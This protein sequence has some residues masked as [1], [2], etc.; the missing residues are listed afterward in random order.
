MRRNLFSL[1]LL[2]CTVCSMAGTLDKFTITPE[3][4][5][6]VT[7]DD[8]KQVT[9]TFPDA[10]E[11]EGSGWINIAVRDVN[12][13]D[14]RPPLLYIKVD[15]D[16]KM[17]FEGNQVI[18]D[19]SEAADLKERHLLFVLNAP[20]FYDKDTKDY[21]S[22][23]KFTYNLPELPNT[24][25]TMVVTPSMDRIVSPVNIRDVTI[26]FPDV[27]IM[28]FA[29]LFDSNLEVWYND[30]KIQ[31]LYPGDNASRDDNKVSFIIYSWWIETVPGKLELKFGDKYFKDE[32]SGSESK[33]FTLAWNIDNKQD[34]GIAT[35]LSDG[36]DSDNT[37]TI[38]GTRA[39][40]HVN[41]IVIKNSK[42]VLMNKK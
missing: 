7:A 15:K 1:F 4:G 3:P 14:S 24:F 11:I 36:K 38:N 33:A 12:R 39:G 37:Y 25:E 6:Q 34:D 16:N 19:L 2:L 21:C 30:S 41:G 26:T 40:N 22:D 23:I 17:T 29:N 28:S 42:K 18:L 31:T 35:I 9:I 27:K 5:V 32:E 8:L 20:G 13:D 10:K